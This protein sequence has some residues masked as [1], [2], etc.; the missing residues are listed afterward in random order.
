ME[1]AAEQ[2][3][4]VMVLDRPNP[5]GYF[6]DGPVLE[7][8]F[9]SFVGMHPV[10]LVYGMTIGEYARMINGEAW[11]ENGVK[12][13]LDVIPLKS[14][15]R[16]KNY[17]L[18]VNPSPNLPNQ[19]AVLLYPSLVLFEGTEVSVGRG[20]DY[21]FQCFGHP[22]YGLGSFIFKPRSMTSST[23]P[24]WEGDQC[25]GAYLANLTP[26]DIMSPKQLNLSYL[27]G[28]YEVLQSKTLFF[29]KDG[30]F[31]KL[32]G[33]D[34]LKKALELGISEGSIREEWAEELEKFNE[35]RAKY[36]MY[37]D[38]DHQ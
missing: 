12:C 19:V 7:P 20:T 16:E 17:E 33:T 22:K 25:Y 2:G 9:S 21:P 29:R 4:E 5:N 30:Y 18:P 10:P 27:I 26:E 6:I 37:E 28:M 31:N 38:F 32:A 14:Y 13:V 11:L 1:A 8:E 3:K 15:Q 23:S 36:L 34:Q 35:I 24:K